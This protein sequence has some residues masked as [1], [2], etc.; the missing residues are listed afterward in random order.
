MVRYGLIAFAP[1]LIFR[2]RCTLYLCMAS[3][4]SAALSWIGLTMITK[5]LWYLRKILKTV[6]SAK[7]FLF[8]RLL[9][10]HYSKI[11]SNRLV[12]AVGVVY[13]TMFSV[14]AA[15]HMLELLARNMTPTSIQTISSVTL[16]L[17]S[18]VTSL[19]YP[20]YFQV[21]LSD[22]ADIDILLRGKSEL[23]IPFTRFLFLAILVTQ[24]S[25]VGP[26]IILGYLENEEKI[27]VSNFLFV[28]YFV[29]QCGIIYLTAVMV[30]EIL[31][32]R[33]RKFREYLE[34][35]LPQLC[36]AQD[37]RTAADDIYK[38]MLL[39][40][41][42]LEAFKK[43]NA[44]TKTA[45][46][47]A[48]TISFCKVLAGVFDLISSTN[49]HIKLLR[50]HESAL[51]GVLPLVPAMLAAFIQGELNR[52]KL[53][54]GNLILNANE[55]SVHD[56]LRDCQL[57]LEH[58]PFKYSVCRL[59]TVDLSLVITIINLYVTSLIAMIQFSHFYN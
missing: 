2:I 56:A 8:L 49:T 9:G 54:I 6:I 38:C 58:R 15:M 20:E 30:F 35:H 50:V 13:C 36:R 33:V 14:Y 42:I 28:G 4:A 45:I 55:E 3:T 43:T 18:V 1:I 23:D 40:Q 10:G 19:R 59:Y 5:Q 12:C 25:L 46:L 41:T 16:Y 31:W 57:Y 17:S 48:T 11:S 39:Y 21:Y 51:D 34:K 24:V 29:L 47:M 26:Y 52:I 7:T 44:P 53:F 22:M 27:Q 37:E 32:Y